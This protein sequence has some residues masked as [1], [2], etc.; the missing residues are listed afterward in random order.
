MTIEEA[1][2]AFVRDP[3]TQQY[4]DIAMRFNDRDAAERAIAFA[5]S[6]GYERGGQEY[7][8]RSASICEQVIEEAFAEEDLSSPAA[9]VA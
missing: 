2:D 1:T 6:S 3:Q 7:L 4:I 5:F 9:K 8:Q